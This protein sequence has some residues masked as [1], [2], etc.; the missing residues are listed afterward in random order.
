MFIKDLRAVY[1]GIFIKY[2]SPSRF[3]VSRTIWA[4]SRTK[5]FWINTFAD[6]KGIYGSDVPI[7][8]LFDTLPFVSSYIRWVWWFRFGVPCST[9]ENQR[10]VPQQHSYSLK[11][12]SP[13]VPCVWYSV[14]WF[15][16]TISMMRSDK[17]VYFQPTAAVKP[18]GPPVTPQ[19]PFSP[20]SLNIFPN[21]ISANWGPCN[22]DIKWKAG[23]SWTWISPTQSDMSF[24]GCIFLLW[25]FVYQIFGFPFYYF[26][27]RHPFKCLSTAQISP[28]CV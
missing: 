14:T 27:G 9:D 24:R 5:I 10:Y 1:L 26:V 12:P 8:I 22:K 6:S 23:I 13:R 4:S 16:I 15:Q 28:N 18:D 2:Y 19:T 3:E 25:R 7:F 11:S 17:P 21:L 20:N